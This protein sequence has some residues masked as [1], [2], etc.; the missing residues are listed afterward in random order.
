M[1]SQAY[2]FNP[3]ERTS[4][5]AG[6]GFSAPRLT[7]T[8]RNALSLGVNGKGMMVYDTT[9]TTLCIWTGVA[10]EFINDNSNAIVSVKDFGA[11]G[12]GVTDDT[13]SIIAALNSGAKNVF[14]PSGQ[15]KTTATINR[16]TTIRMFGD[17]A[18]HSTIVA[19]HN[20]SIVRTA[21]A[22]FSGDAYNSMEDMG[23]KNG[24]T[25]NSAIGIELENLNQPSF[26]RI[27]IELGPIIGMRQIYVLNGEFE[28]IS[29]INC[30][31]I[32]IYLFSTGLAAGTNR[33]VFQ[34]MNLAYNNRGIV[35]DVNG[36][37]SNVFNDV[38]IESCTSYP[39]EISNCNQLTFNGL[40][41]EGNTQSIWCRGGDFVTFRDCFNVSVIPFIRG[42]PNFVTTNVQIERLFDLSAGGVGT[43]GNYM[44]LEYGQIHFP[45][46]VSLSPNA[47][48]LDDYREGT[49]TPSDA[50]GAGLVFTLGACRY[51]KIG[52]MVQCNFNITY[53]VTVNGANAVIGTLPFLS[54]H[55]NAV[56]I[57]FST[58]A[59]V[60]R[61]TTGAGEFFFVLYDSL[62]TLIL[63]SQLSGTVLRGTIVYETNA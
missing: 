41:L 28:E 32:G 37:L 47:T 35:V 27:R 31:D 48:T 57:S 20:G 10:W 43:N 46:T 13:A 36:G 62:G 1:S 29:V 7:T 58:V 9:L 12:D 63:N 52:R 17:G 56:S 34:C 24:P 39:V 6:D 18:F 42:S 59:S 14:F 26:K 53:P 50:S 25:F 30:T 40:Y 33:N 61:G 4:A 49:W 19:Y 60:V 44:G 15:Y 51:T 2:I 55:L 54:T 38:A 5:A 16:P 22:I 3:T 8:D 23:I 21:P 11:K 45:T